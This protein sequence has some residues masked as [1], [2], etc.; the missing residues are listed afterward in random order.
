V[1]V[2]PSIVRVEAV[3][4][5]RQLDRAAAVTHGV[6][7]VEAREPADDGGQTPFTNLGIYSRRQLRT[8]LPEN[9]RRV[10]IA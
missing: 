10:A 3:G 1:L 6:L 7:A 4:V 5:D 2:A 9:G 8:A